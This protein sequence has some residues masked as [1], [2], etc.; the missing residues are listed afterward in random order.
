MAQF[1]SFNVARTLP[2]AGGVVVALF[3]TI[4]GRTALPLLLSFYAI[5]TVA[6]AL[7]ASA[8]V[9]RCLPGRGCSARVPTRQLYRF[10]VLALVGA[11]NPVDALGLDQAAVGLFLG[12]RALGLYVVG[13]AFSNLSNFLLSSI[14]LI[15]SPRVTSARKPH[16][17]I[18]LIRRY[19][20]LGLAV[21]ALETAVVV[22]ALGWLIPLLFG[23]QFSASVGVARFLAVTGLIVGLRRLL[24][25]LAQG[26]G[27]PGLA[28]VGET[29]ALILLL[30]SIPVWLALLG[31]YGA[32]VAVALS[33]AAGAGIVAAGL[34][35]PSLG[36]R[37]RWHTS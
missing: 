16:A 10:G 24:V 15:G 20:I 21:G 18:S 17:R 37:E 7:V 31:T 1:R 29:I 27:R 26:A 2:A 6:A 14:G 22:A 35:R 12:E 32:A 30:A 19:L 11:S 34:R 3:V 4:Q 8:L 33:S 25:L 9:R 13:G 36:L 5:A 28:S 23:T